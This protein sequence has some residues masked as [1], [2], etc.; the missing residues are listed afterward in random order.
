MPLTNNQR[1]IVNP[2][3]PTLSAPEGSP[4]RSGVGYSYTFWRNRFVLDVIHESYNSYYE[5]PSSG[6]TLFPNAEP[7][8]RPNNPPPR[9]DQDGDFR[10]P[11]LPDLGLGVL[12]ITDADLLAYCALYPQNGKVSTD[13]NGTSI[14]VSLS[15]EEANLQLNAISNSLRQVNNYYTETAPLSYDPENTKS[16]YR[17]VTIDPN[18]S[19][20]Y[21]ARLRRALGKENQPPLNADPSL[22]NT[23]LPPDI[24]S[25]ISSN[26]MVDLDNW[27]TN[28]D[29]GTETIKTYYNSRDSRFYYTERTNNTSPDYYDLSYYDHEDQEDAYSTIKNNLE[30]AL[31]K[32]VVGILKAV[33][34]FSRANQNSILNVSPKKAYILTHLDVRPAS[35]WCYSV[36]VNRDIIDA[37]PEIQTMSYEEEELWVLEK[38]QTLASPEKTPI[39]HRKTFIFDDLID[40]IRS[41]QQMLEL[42]SSDMAEEGIFSLPLASSFGV[43]DPESRSGLLFLEDEIARLNGFPDFMQTFFAYN[44]KSILPETVIELYFDE[45]YRLLHICAN[46]EL[47]TRG[48]GNINYIRREDDT[49]VGKILNAFSFLTSTTFSYILHSPEI[50]EKFLMVAP[51][52]VGTES[53][54]EW[55]I[56]LPQYTYPQV[57]IDPEAI[58]IEHE[59]NS[60]L[61]RRKNTL[62]QRLSRVLDVPADQAEKL[63][64]A[65]INDKKWVRQRVTEL[66]KGV[67]CS[68]AQAQL[69]ND[70]VGFWNAANEK[71]NVRAIIRESIQLLRRELSNDAVTSIAVSA[72]LTPEGSQIG[73]DVLRHADR[74]NQQL[75]LEGSRNPN[76][77]FGQNLNAAYNSDYNRAQLT[78]QVEEVINDQIFCAIDS[79][80]NVLQNG[81][82]DPVGIPPSASKFVAREIHK[83]LTVKLSKIKTISM[84]KDQSEIYLKMIDTAIQQLLKSLVTGIARDVFAAALGCA[85]NP[86]QTDQ[87]DNSLKRY[88]FGYSMLSEHVGPVNLREIAVATGLVTPPLN[89]G[90][91]PIPPTPEQ[92]Q[93]FLKDISIMCTPAELQQLL[94]G[95]ADNVLYDLI[96]ETVSNGVVRVKIGEEKNDSGDKV[97]IYHIID[98]QTYSSLTKTKDIIREF[99][100]AVGD[101]LIPEEIDSVDDLSFQSPLEA[102]CAGKDPDVTPLRLRIGVDQIQSQYIQ[103]MDARINKINNLCQWLQDLSNIEAM[104]GDIFDFMPVMDW[105]NNILEL[106]AMFSNFI[107]SAIAELW[108]SWFDE[109]PPHSSAA[110][111]KNIYNTRMGSELFFQIRGNLI[112]RPQHLVAT[113]PD[114]VDPVY[115]LGGSNGVTTFDLNDAGGLNDT[116][117]LGNPYIVDKA[118]QYENPSSIQ[119]GGPGGAPFFQ[120]LTLPYQPSLPGT[121]QYQTSYYS[122]R[123]APFSF[124]ER[125]AP[126]LASGPLIGNTE[127]LTYANK[128]LAKISQQSWKL[129][130]YTG[131]VSPIFLSSKSVVNGGLNLTGIKIEADGAIYEDLASWNPGPEDAEFNPNSGRPFTRLN[132]PFLYGISSIGWEDNNDYRPDLGTKIPS[133]NDID[134]QRLLNYYFAGYAADPV[135]DRNG[136][137]LQ[138]SPPEGTPNILPLVSIANWTTTT[139]RQ[140]NSSY[141]NEV[142][143]RRMPQYVNAINRDALKVLDDKCVTRDDARKAHAILKVVQSRMQKFFLNAMITATAY[144]HW[145]NLSTRKLV[146]DYLSKNIV[147]ELSARSILGLVYENMDFVKKVYADEPENNFTFSESNTPYLNLVEFVE[148]LYIGMLNNI[149]KYSEYDQVAKSAYSYYST[150]YVEKT[151]NDNIT[152]DRYDLTLRLFFERMVF[153]LRA[154]ASY[155]LTPDEIPQAIRYIED[156]LLQGDDIK[157]IGNYYFPLGALTATQL[158]Y[159]DYS[160]NTAGRY[161][162]TN[163]RLELEEA[164]ADDGLLTAFRGLTT[165]QFSV[166]YRGFPQS[167]T[168][169]TQDNEITYYNTHEVERRLAYIN[170]IITDFADSVTN[171]EAID[172]SPR[173]LVNMSFQDFEQFVMPAVYNEIT[174]RQREGLSPIYFFNRNEEPVGGVSYNYDEALRILTR[175][176]YDVLT[177]QLITDGAS[178]VGDAYQ[179]LYGTL[180]DRQRRDYVGS[181]LNLA[182][183]AGYLNINSDVNPS[184][185]TP[186]SFYENFSL[187]W[188]SIKELSDGRRRTQGYNVQVATGNQQQDEQRFLYANEA[189]LVDALISRYDAA[190]EEARTLENIR[191]ERNSLEKLIIE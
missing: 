97:P 22:T 156:R 173:Q 115:I 159:A 68:T 96:Y 129:I 174:N 142:G 113:T 144:P 19:A 69:A 46:G 179:A 121:Y 29:P 12:F 161:S 98:P 23:I 187:F 40:Y 9:D 13:E 139:E 128:V 105:Y 25:Y 36:Q 180:V 99:F 188:T 145:N 77:T 177:S 8:Q 6:F 150:E 11:P 108:S 147:K 190:V 80:G 132:A 100:A 43:D 124:R 51:G 82:L 167:I 152:V 66:V 184:T 141:Y 165:N 32:G 78:K 90:E 83:P 169:Y 125:I 158:I 35:R 163:Y 186:S 153:N 17:L 1:N 171:F 178:Y 160:L 39:A 58:K 34:K 61:R 42:L 109:D 3:A 50:H 155:G 133:I 20:E 122:S 185:F 4:V 26:A 112:I 140:L 41:T 81:F 74:L 89:A 102:Y 110:D 168:A 148:A 95:E 7:A 154:G 111:V 182:E 54:E 37:L 16:R 72:G 57:I 162:Q 87:L 106:L 67:N 86:S 170:G 30:R 60:I 65:K 149:T 33:G 130:P 136:V 84:K 126:E 94:F 116:P 38:A 56:F 123:V 27:V 92:M 183:T 5:F 18:H 2:N 189:V 73:R 75:D 53:G 45:Q 175:H 55:T 31:E 127:Q 101:A 64:Q 47:L 146:C 172:F 166:A 143:K 14:I 62:F 151:G 117:I 118:L 134:V 135:G 91:D 48:L 10:F 59:K 119:T 88:D 63:Y 52:G 138:Y 71:N 104:I 137:G 107:A 15:S 191:T 181:Q 79:F 24:T 21:T 114:F 131:F 120:S 85:P 176:W 76:A 70:I 28:C 103:V 44:K 93:A 157:N 49:P 164:G